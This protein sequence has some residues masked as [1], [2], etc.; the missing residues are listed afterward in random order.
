MQTAEPKTYPHKED[1]ITYEK[2]IIDAI[3][4]LP[5]E[6]RLQAAAL[7][8]YTLLRKNL[9]QAV[10]GE[11]DIIVQKYNKIQAPIIEKS[12][13]VI[14]GERAPNDEEIQQGVQFLSDEDKTKLSEHL[15]AAP[16]EDYWFKVLTNCNTLSQDIFEA[17]HPLLKKITKIEHIPEDNTENF[18]IKFHFAPNEYFENTHLGVKFFMIDQGEPEKTEGTEIKWKEGKDITKKT[19]Q[20]K[21]KNKKTGKTRTVTKTVDAES[22]FN[23]FKSIQPGEGEGDDEEEGDED[24]ERIQINFEIGSTIQEEIMSY[25]LEYYLGLREGEDYGD[26]MEGEDDEDDDGDDDDDDEEDKKPKKGGAAKPKG[27]PA[28]G[29]DKKPA[30]KECKQQ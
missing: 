18:E 9:D 22:F 2:E 12:N 3:K 17:D 25:H 6:Q 5:L 27:K 30:E 29:G 4:K 13:Q 10:D 20:K 14:S 7:N 21:Q 28:E 15:T 19:V 16:I 23:F 8:H 1:D 11:I 26:D 24:I